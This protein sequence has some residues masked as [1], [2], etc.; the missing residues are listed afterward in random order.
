MAVVRAFG[1]AVFQFGDP[2]AQSSDL[3]FLLFL[4]VKQ[5]L[6]QGHDGLRA[7]FIDRQ[8]LFACHDHI[9]YC[10]LRN[11]TK[12]R[13]EQLSSRT[14]CDNKIHREFIAVCLAAQGWNR[15]S[16]QE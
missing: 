13:S 15:M 12:E 10:A 16:W 6:G 3:L 11:V 14:I 8:Y 4:T 7:T 1:K 9:A 5:R 2:S